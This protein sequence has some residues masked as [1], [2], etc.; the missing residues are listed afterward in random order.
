MVESPPAYDTAP[1]ELQLDD[2]RVCVSFELPRDWSR[3][4]LQTAAENVA[5]D[6]AGRLRHRFVAEADDLRL[7]ISASHL[8]L[9]MGLAPA[10]VYW[11]DLYGIDDLPHYEERWCGYP[12]MSGWFQLRNQPMACRA[13]AWLQLE[14]AV[15]EVQLHGRADDRQRLQDVWSTLRS[16]LKCESV[17][18]PRVVLDAPQPWWST[19]QA[20][21]AQG[22]SDAALALAEQTHEAEALLVQS[23]M[24]AERMRAALAAGQAQIA[25]DAWRQA[26]SCA[27][28]YAASA[29]SG[30]E[31]AARSLMCDRVVRELGPEPL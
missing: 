30:G 9:P 13:I 6:A 14:D 5:P 11:L 4:T 15:V 28:A 18:E 23:D 19:V 8:S 20:L 29:T 2:L 16:S 1:I 24:H 17:G 10:V 12:A 21:R 27:R 22:K 26:V 7:E 31:G 3:H 25:R